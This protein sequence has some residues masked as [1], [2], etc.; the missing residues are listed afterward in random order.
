MA[1][2][3]AR[4]L[5]N[6]MT[7]SERKLWR[8]LSKRQLGGNRFRRQHPL[9]LYIVDFVCLSRRFIVEV[10]GGQHAEPAQQAHDA[11]RTEWLETQGYRVL[12]V[13][14][15][16]VFDNLDGVAETIYQELI[17]RPLVARSRR[18][19][20][21]PPPSRAK[22]ELARASICFGRLSCAR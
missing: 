20:R 13:S 14:N 6:D 16:E 11:R 15:T 17:R 4:Q 18:Q 19:P 8:E 1:N 22:N 7:D 5:R 12:R 10:N 21:P 9:G 2:Q 3:R